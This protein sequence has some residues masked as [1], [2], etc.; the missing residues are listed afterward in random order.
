M[1]FLVNRLKCVVGEAYRMGEEGF[2][3]R[4][5]KMEVGGIRKWFKGVCR[6]F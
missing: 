4:M 3:K 2:S 5:N 1:D 6:V